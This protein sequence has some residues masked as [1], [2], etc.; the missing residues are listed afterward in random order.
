MGLEKE[1]QLETHYLKGGLYENLV[2]LEMLKGRLNLGLP[3]N[4]YF[5]RDQTG[6][7]IDCIAE[8][9]GTIKCRSQDLIL[10]TL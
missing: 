10:Q 4:F 6:H 8:W 2:I 5:W 3:T 1:E 7:E 9:G